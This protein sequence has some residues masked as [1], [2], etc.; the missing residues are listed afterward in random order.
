M[1]LEISRRI[2]EITDL[3]IDKTT[4]NLQDVISN[5][6]SL[7]AMSDSDRSLLNSLVRD[8]INSAYEMLIERI[9]SKVEKIVRDDIESK[10][11][12]KKK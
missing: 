9:S 3:S 10:V 7:K 11:A 4:M 1:K 12:S 6:E 2:K 5:K 8:S